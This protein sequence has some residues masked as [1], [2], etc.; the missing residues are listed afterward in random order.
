M[1]I[2]LHCVTLT[3]GVSFGAFKT[4]VRIDDKGEENRHHT[5]SFERSGLQGAV[6][7]L[8]RSGV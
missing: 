4:G 7:P 1:D 3:Y 5:G 6:S 8:N 2:I